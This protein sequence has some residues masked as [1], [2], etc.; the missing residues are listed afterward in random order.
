MSVRICNNCNI[1]Q[2]IDQFGPYKLRGKV[3]RRGKCNKCRREESRKRYAEN[4]HIQERMKKNARDHRIRKV[5]GLESEDVEQMISNQ[6]NKCAICKVEFSKLPNIDH[7][8]TTGKV[9]GILCWQCNTG[10]GQFKD[11]PIRL[12]N[13]AKY[14]EEN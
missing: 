13:A 2:S 3:V 5:Y 7:C 8:H 4:P 12:R 6:D 14:L 10:L 11:D 9:R 1:E